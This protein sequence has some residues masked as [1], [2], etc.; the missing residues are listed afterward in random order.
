MRALRH[1]LGRILAA[2]S[3]FLADSRGLS[4]VEYVI[5]LVL[6]AAVALGTWKGFGS[7]VVG[8]LDSAKGAYA[9]QVNVTPGGNPGDEK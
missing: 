4:T 6:V 3:G 7:M 2:P 9:T 1:K 8:K 5:I